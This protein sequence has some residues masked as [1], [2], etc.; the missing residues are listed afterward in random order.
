MNE[1]VV[2]KMDEAKSL[3]FIESCVEETL[4]AV[5]AT[6]S[7]LRMRPAASLPIDTD[8]LS[9]AVLNSTMLSFPEGMNRRYKTIIKRTFLFADVT[10][11][12]KYP[13]EKD[14]ILRFQH[15]IKGL[16]AMGWSS[17]GS[18]ARI[19]VEESSS[20]LT[21]SNVVLDIMETMLSGVTGGVGAVM[22]TGA[23][24]AITALKGNTEALKLY[25][26]NGKKSEGSS[27][28]IASCA[29]DKE[30]DVY[31]ALGGISYFATSGNTHIAFF[32]KTHSAA[33]VYQTK[34]IFT[35][36]EDD[37]TP[38]KEEAANKFYEAIDAALEL[39]FGI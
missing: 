38:R 23:S 16:T 30:G 37:Y 8:K 25:E 4:C 35:I 10:A 21:M 14:E 26:K 27:F 33:R 3:E 19:N 5:G 11:Q 13:N 24:T 22:K 17:F 1:V 2:A 7:V 12:I 31:M 36:Y 6:G 34:G 32:D 39:E 20:G 29:Q 9:A 15:M 18:P 28:G